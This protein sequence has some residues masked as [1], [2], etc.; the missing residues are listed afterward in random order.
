MKIF[1]MG[2]PELIIILIVALLLF[3]PKNLPKIG[4]ALGKTMSNLRSGMESGSESDPEADGAPASKTAAKA[5][6][7]KAEAVADDEPADYEDP[8][9]SRMDRAALHLKHD[10]ERERAE[11]AAAKAGHA[12]AASAAH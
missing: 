1:G 6:T 10:Q 4:T 11:K 3:G 5:Q 2:M 9:L 8:S 12:H 7:V